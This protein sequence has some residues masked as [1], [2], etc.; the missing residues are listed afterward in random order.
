MPYRLCISTLLLLLGLSTALATD[1]QVFLL[2]GQSNMDGYGKV[3]ELPEELRGIQSEIPIFH[4]NT[5]PDG[6]EDGS[7]G[8]GLWAP[9][10]PGHGVGF[11]SSGETNYY[12]DRF[13]LELTFSR[14]LQQ[15][16][17]DMPIALI[18]YSRGGTA[19][20]LRSGAARKF[21]CWDPDFMEGKGVNQYDHCL[22]AIR[23]ALAEKDI[24]ADG[25]NDRLFPAGIIWLQGESDADSKEVAESYQ[26]NL[27][28]LMAL[29]RSA[30]GS[31]E[32]PVIIVRINDSGRDREDG[33][34]WD[35]GDT[36]RAEQASFVKTDC[37]AVLVTSTDGYGYC[38][39]W[40]YDSSGYI[41]LGRCCAEACFG[42]AVKKLQKTIDP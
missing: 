23:T 29:L 2:A 38:D 40:H 1:Y 9:L 11:R 20:D 10:Q 13:G 5:A 21:G 25:E 32:I 22:V 41:D 33:R 31:E 30:M 39:P 28:E 6:T 34:V 42:S 19:L 36:V 3:S 8:R 15:L 12:S 7:G 37:N 18:K 35:F 14:R 24:N 17:S 27:T 16:N 4:G 26:K